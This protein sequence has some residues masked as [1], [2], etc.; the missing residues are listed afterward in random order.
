[1]FAKRHIDGI[2]PDVIE[3]QLRRI[4]TSSLF[5]HSRRYPGFLEFVVR[6]TLEGREDEL[7]E[8][9]V[10]VEAFGRASDYDLNADPIVR[11][12][13]GEVRK[14]LAQYYYQPGREHELR[15]EL[16][17]GSYVPEFRLPPTPAAP[18]DFVQD[19]PGPTTPSLTTLSL[20]P[21]HLSPKR[22]PS[23]SSLS[24]PPKDQNLYR[25]SLYKWKLIAGVLAGAFAV[26]AAFAII[27]LLHRTSAVEAFWKPMVDANG[28]VLISVG[29]VVAMVNSF[30][31]APPANSVSG[32]PLSSD[33]IAVSDATALSAIQQVLSVRAKS[34]SLASSTSTSFSDLQ[35]GP[36]VLISGF[37]NPWTMRITEP[38]RFHFVR[39]S[40]DDYTIQDRQDSSKKWVINTAGPF[41]KMSHDYGLVARFHDPTT[42]QIVMVAAGIGENGTVA[43]SRLLTEPRLLSELRKEGKYP[44]YDQNF[45]CVVETQI[46]DGKPGPPRVVALN[47]W[48]QPHS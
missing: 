44:R 33:P 14:R 34:S 26:S 31:V 40:T 2:A 15:I 27:P 13:A 41:V 10:G 12:I 28:P 36:F 35:A 18:V 19:L 20:E 22:E 16:N 48:E 25:S 8:R 46:I 37:N 9:T 23:V 4:R 45:E 5:S 38:L 7:K 17:P 42:E 47:L 39:T 29:S 32:H 30:A 6:K 43:A 21:I 24:L 1:M 3:E 11:V